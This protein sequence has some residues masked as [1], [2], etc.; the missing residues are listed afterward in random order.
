MPRHFSLGC[1]RDARTV[2]ITRLWLATFRWVAPDGR[3]WAGFD[4]RQRAPALLVALPSD[5]ERAGFDWPTLLGKRGSAWRRTSGTAARCPALLVASPSCLQRCSAVTVR[6]SAA[7]PAEAVC[8]SGAPLF[9]G[10]PLTWLPARPQ[11]VVLGAM[12][13]RRAPSGRSSMTAPA[14]TR[15]TTRS[16]SR[17]VR[18]LTA[19]DMKYSASPWVSNLATSV[20][21]AM[22]VLSG[23][24]RKRTT[25]CIIPSSYLPPLGEL[26]CVQHSRPIACVSGVHFGTATGAWTHLCF[27]FRRLRLELKE[28]R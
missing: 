7:A 14:S 16:Q 21:A 9:A 4:W 6:V 13:D 2:R 20:P 18:S 3:L 28:K 19:S 22:P 27:L 23:A 5:L 17:S 25:N 10:R 24:V 8:A 1:S 26:P 12:G 11:S 15:A